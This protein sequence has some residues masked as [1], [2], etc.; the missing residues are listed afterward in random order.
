MEN[1]HQLPW[2][3]LNAS[4][5]YLKLD[6]KIMLPRQRWKK[7]ENLHYKLISWVFFYLD[8]FLLSTCISPE[9]LVSGH[10]VLCI[11]KSNRLTAFSEDQL[12]NHRA[13][14]HKNHKIL[15]GL[16]NEN[17]GILLHFISLSGKGRSQI[18]CIPSTLNLEDIKYLLKTDS[19]LR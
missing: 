16:R 4:M 11:R 2:I 9:I 6:L 14:Y 3:W 13:V 12:N 18:D 5:D 8:S 15:T 10:P 17:S 19:C 7:N 1:F